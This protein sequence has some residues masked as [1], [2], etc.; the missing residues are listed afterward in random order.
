[1]KFEADMAILIA[2]FKNLMYIKILSIIRGCN[3]KYKSI[4]RDWH[5]F[6]F[7]SNT[8]LLNEF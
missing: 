2:L 5:S 4:T 3:Y 6:S 8:S 7:E 1:M